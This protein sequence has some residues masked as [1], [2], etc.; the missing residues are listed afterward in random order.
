MMLKVVWARNSNSYITWWSLGLTL[1]LRYAV[2]NFTLGSVIMP[3]DE[4]PAQKNCFVSVRLQTVFIWV[5]ALAITQCGQPDH[6]IWPTLLLVFQVLW[7]YFKNRVYLTPP[8]HLADLR[9]RIVNGGVSMTGGKWLTWLP[10]Q[11]SLTTSSESPWGIIFHNKH[12][13]NIFS[14]A[15]YC[16]KL[17]LILYKYILD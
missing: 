3:Q 17:A 6:W 8:R 7:S 1:K 10:P 11:V 16:D 12:F 5:V 2:S 15:G 14:T 13:L 4:Q 9:Q